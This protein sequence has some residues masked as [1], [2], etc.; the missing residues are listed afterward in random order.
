MGPTPQAQL[1][2]LPPLLHWQD[3]C[4]KQDTQQQPQN[5]ALKAADSLRMAWKFTL[6]FNSRVALIT[7]A[8]TWHW[9]Y[10]KKP[11]TQKQQNN[12]KT[13]TPHQKKKNTQ[14]KPQE[15]FR[16][17]LKYHRGVCIKYNSNN[18]N[19]IGHMGS[20]SQRA[21]TIFSWHSFRS[22]SH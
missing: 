2:E 17:D 19:T 15:I 6:P 20:K 5:Q 11:Q 22:L 18:I 1:G 13:E 4:C 21:K 7:L 12:K 14:Q 3:H 9:G 16:G 10:K 8:T